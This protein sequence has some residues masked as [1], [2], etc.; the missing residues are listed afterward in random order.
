MAH[1]SFS[2]LP[3]DS[4]VPRTLAPSLPT[5]LVVFGEHEGAVSDLMR[6]PV[7]HPGGR[8]EGEGGSRVKREEG[9]GKQVTVR[10]ISD[11]IKKGR[12]GGREGEGMRDHASIFTWKARR[13]FSSS[14]P[15]GAM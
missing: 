15:T 5:H 7:Q 11:K 14:T 9:E 13:S 10:G 8:L 6:E 3:P 1:K 12:E 4:S 2:S